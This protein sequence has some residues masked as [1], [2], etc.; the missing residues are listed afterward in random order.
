MNIM[1]AIVLTL[2]VSLLAAASVPSAAAE[3]RGAWRGD[4]RTFHERDFEHWRGGHWAHEYHDGRWGW[5]WVIPTLGLWY[6]YAQPVYPYPDP[7]VPPVAV[8]PP[9]TAPGAPPPAQYWYYCAS[10]KT[11]YP[12]VQSCPEGWRP[13]PATPP[14]VPA[15]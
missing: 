14:G 13:V 10:A 5:W 2:A 9:V 7:Y 3:R 11:Y 6:W 8:Y 4:I 1:R 15:Q 12:Y